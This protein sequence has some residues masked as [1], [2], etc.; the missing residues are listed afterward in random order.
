MVNKIALCFIVSY[1]SGCL[2]KENVWIRWINQ[3]KRIYGNESI[4]IYVHYKNYEILSPFLKEHAIPH[5]HIAPTN[6]YHMVPA[7][8][9]LLQYA[10]T[11]DINNVW[12]CTLTESCIPIMHPK[13][14]N[15]LFKENHCSSIIDIQRATWNVH[16]HRRANLRMFPPKFRLQNS[17]WF[18]LTR[19]HVRICIDFMNIYTHTFF[20]I[21]KGGLAN[22]SIFAIML[23]VGG[24]FNPN[25]PNTTHI[26]TSS[27][28]ANW[29]KRTSPTSPYVFTSFSE[30][31]LQFINK[32]INTNKYFVFL[33]KVSQSV[34]DDAILSII[35]HN[36]LPHIQT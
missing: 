21:C 18:I 8:M 27:T 26:N 6:Y 33:R 11:A 5:T 14:F 36:I 1:D 22:E 12:F 3:Y 4:N 13:K 19:S 9:S 29:H 25:I 34:G 24:V 15:E 2:E 35:N 10:A 16:L 30:N 28:I 23:L 32:H 7:Y 20:T 31:E 17:P